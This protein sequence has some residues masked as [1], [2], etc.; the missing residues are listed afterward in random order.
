M[1]CDVNGQRQLVRH[2]NDIVLWLTGN[3]GDLSPAVSRINLNRSHAEQLE[4]SILVD[5]LHKLFDCTSVSILHSVAFS[6][7]WRF[8]FTC[9]M[10]LTSNAFHLNT[11]GETVGAR[12]STTRY[13]FTGAITLWSSRC[14]LRHMLHSCAAWSAEGD[15]KRDRAD[16]QGVR[17]HD[18]IAIG[19]TRCSS[20]AILVSE[21]ARVSLLYSL[22]TCEK[23]AHALFIL[24]DTRL[25]QLML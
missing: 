12:T 20:T 6:S 15:R 11:Q 19:R 13:S 14:L 7:M 24:H 3:S 16:G 21:K 17:S 10:I 1:C 5:A 2:F 18:S 25:V 8:M 23:R 22:S 4:P 9:S